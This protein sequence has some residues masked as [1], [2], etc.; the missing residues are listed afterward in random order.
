MSVCK[1]RKGQSTAEYV[2]V[3]GLMVGVIIAMQT[4]V[5]RGLQ[6][7]M[8]EVTDTVDNAAFIPG[9]SEAEAAGGGRAVPTF[10]AGNQYEPYYLRSRFE[11]DR[12]GEDQE[13]MGAGGRIHKET[14][15]E[16]QVTQKAGGYQASTTPENQ[17]GP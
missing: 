7:R 11:T 8:R 3:L 15:R 12:D 6:G 2:I 14:W 17:T 13:Q 1:L 4:F 10:T 5:K 16:E 9:G